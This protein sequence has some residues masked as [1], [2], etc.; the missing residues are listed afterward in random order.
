M[1]SFYQFMTL[2]MIIIAA[3]FT[4]MIINVYVTIYKTKKRDHSLKFALTNAGKVFYIVGSI[5]HIVILIGCTIL[6]ILFAM[7]GKAVYYLNAVTVIA[8][9]SLI[10]SFQVANI[11]LVGQ[12]SMLV[13]RMLVD[14]QKMKKVDLNYH[15]ELS[16]V[17]SQKSFK[18]STR[19]VDIPVLR[20]A[21]SRRS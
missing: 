21:I 7:K 9:Y 12:K 20:R 6:A 2:L 13:G 10:Y 19:F 8:L 5:L 17:Y 3:Y 1:D 11:T 18:F 4:Y 16:F 15:H 14:Y